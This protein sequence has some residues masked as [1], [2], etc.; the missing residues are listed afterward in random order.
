MQEYDDFIEMCQRTFTPFAP[1]ESPEFFFGRLTEIARIKQELK[2]AGRQLA[3]YGDR[4]IGKSSLAKVTPFFCKLD[5]ANCYIARC[6]HESNYERIFG[7]ILRRAGK[8]TLLDAIQSVTSSESGI[9]K[10]VNTKKKSEQQH[11]FKSIPEVNSLSPGL[12]LE[13]F[14]DENGLIIID[15]FD[16]VEDTRTHRLLAE[17]LKQFSDSRCPTRIIVV[18]VADSIDELFKAHSSISRCVGSIKLER[19]SQTSLYEIMQSDKFSTKSGWA[20]IKG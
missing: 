7:E 16:V 18:G 1:I 2:S 3:I 11:S 8:R 14:E 10:V 15:E 13:Q 17:T 4:G 5:E 19:M 9:S 12:I 6:T 20:R